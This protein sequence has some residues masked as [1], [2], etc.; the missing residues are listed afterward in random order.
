MMDSGSSP[1]RDQSPPD[2]GTSSR[3]NFRRRIEFS[4]ECGVTGELVYRR[5]GVLVQARRQDRLHSGVLE[6]V[7]TRGQGVFITWERDTEERQETESSNVIINDQVRSSV[8]QC[9]DVTHHC[10]LSQQGQVAMCVGS[11]PSADWAVIAD[12]APPPGACDTPIT[13]IAR[14][15]FSS[16]TEEGRSPAVKFSSNLEEKQLK[17]VVEVGIKEYPLS[18]SV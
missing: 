17:M 10:L 2:P 6:V 14:V 15:R 8:T 3:Q 7:E 11:P 12:H 1:P 9:H 16:R 4:D 18:N 5:A 13:P